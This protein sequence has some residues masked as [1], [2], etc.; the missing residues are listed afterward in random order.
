MQRQA[1]R[2]KAENVKEICEIIQKY[3]SIGIASLYKVRASQ[4]QELRR[5]LDNK[6]Y[7]RVIK[8][9]TI[10]RAIKEC[11]D[12]PE[13]KDF[14]NHLRGPNIF[15]FTDLNPFELALLLKK[16][17]VEAIARGGDTAAHDVVVPAGN[18]GSPPGPII[19][20]FNAVG[21]PTRIES[22]SVWINRDTLAAKKGEVITARLAAVLSKLDLKTAEIGL[23]MKLVYDDGAVLTE[24]Q[25]RLDLEETQRSIEEAHAWAFNLSLNTTYPLSENIAILLQM[26]HQEAFNL[27]LKARI[28]SQDTVIVL[29]KKAHSEMLSL[30]MRMDMIKGKS[31]S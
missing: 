8:N 25:L 4:L 20:Q 18:T 2:E 29:I 27:A 1:V 12:K 5:K 26:G 31:E 7:L 10:Q 17:K 11:E 22:G 9:S 28:L 19:S 16:N 13:L 6:A 24:E 15:L 14:E 30:S 23:T 21:L 3:E